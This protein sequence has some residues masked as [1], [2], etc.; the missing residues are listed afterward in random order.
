MS[1]GYL[2]PDHKRKQFANDLLSSEDH[3]IA[4]EKGE[5]RSKGKNLLMNGCHQTLTT[6]VS[7]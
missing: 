7:I 6:T 3:L 5:N 4:V 1:G 2:W